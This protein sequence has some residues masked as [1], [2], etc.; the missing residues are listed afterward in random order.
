ML[1]EMSIKNFAIIESLGVSFQKGLT[2][3]TGETGAGKSIIIDAISLVAGGRGSS[4]FVRFG[5]NKAE[6]EGL[7][8]LDNDNHPCI[9]KGK[10]LGIDISDGMVVLHRDILTNGKSI[11]RINGKLVTLGILREIGRTLIDI[12][13][14][15]EHQD[16]MNSERHLPMIDQFD[17]KRTVPAIEEYQQLYNQ[18]LKLKKQLKGLTE[19]E[20]KMAH[21]L[22][23]IQFQLSEIKNAELEPGEEEALINEKSQLSNFER[24]HTSVTRSYKA[25]SGEQQGLDWVGLAMSELEDVSSLNDKL[26]AIFENIS[27]SFYLLEEATSSLRDQIDLLEFDPERLDFIETRLN[28]IRFLKKKYGQTVEDV[29]EYAAKIEDEIDQIQNREVH[30]D[31]LRKNIKEIQND[32]QLEAENLSEIRKQIAEKLK[33]EIHKELKDLYMAKTVFDI[34]FALPDPPEFLS[35]GIDKVEFLISTNPGEPLKPLTKIASGGELSRIMLALKSIF[36]KHQGITSIIFD[37]VDTGV[38]GRVAQSMAEKIYKISNGSQVLCITHLPQVA[39]MADA[40]LYISKETKGD[41]TVTSISELQSEE[42]VKEVAR[43]ISGVE[44]TDL[45]K[46]H[47]S[48]LLQLANQMKVGASTE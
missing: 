46:R 7:F 30:L 14:Q 1:A 22:D 10:E 12:H 44:I 26:K 34:Q 45:T 17:E 11:C 13:G 29:L 15:H 43:M 28:E 33:H 36:S 24:I 6:I 9:E 39:A 2:V 8:L 23:L 48:E 31:R 25:L 41:R 42:K 16:L 19:N 35:T 18:F 5:C 32:L 47:A 21:R 38:S 20:Q 40:H 37:E 4:E 3:L 27:S